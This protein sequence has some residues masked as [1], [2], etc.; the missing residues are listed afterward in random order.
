MRRLGVI[1][2]VAVDWTGSIRSKKSSGNVQ[3]RSALNLSD[4]SAIK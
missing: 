1:W 2:S 3:A 4:K